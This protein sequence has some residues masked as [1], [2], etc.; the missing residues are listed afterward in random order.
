MPTS[1]EG[2]SG[3][4]WLPDRELDSFSTLTLE[5]PELPTVAG[6][7]EGSLCATLIRRSAPP[8]PGRSALLYVHGWN[9]YFFQ[10]HLARQVEE[11]GYDFYAIDLHRYGRSLRTGN[12]AGYCTDLADYFPELEWAARVVREEGHDELVVMGHSTGGLIALLWLVANPEVAKALVLNSPWIE[13]QGYPALRSAIRPMLTAARQ[14][15]ATAVLPIGDGTFYQRSISAS[16]EG[17]WDYNR[18][19]KGDE[20]FNVRVG[21]LAAVMAGHARVAAGLDVQVPVFMAISARSDFSRKW[22]EEMRRADVVLDV[23]RLAASAHHLGRHVTL[24]R[25]EGGMHDLT[26]SDEPARSE[27]FHEMR[28]WLAA[29][30]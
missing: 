14:V 27:F 22:S 7:R 2:G 28:R 24:V 15:S 3:G 23:A 20:A 18:N 9:D 1:S 19:L 29:Y 30:G 4:T 26:L 16:E 5:L 12:L 10:E 8:R 6:E 21:W 25:V 13:L 17:A 11:A